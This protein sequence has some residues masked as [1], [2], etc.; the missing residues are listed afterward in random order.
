MMQVALY[1]TFWKLLYR[2]MK[3]SA[4]KRITEKKQAMLNYLLFLHH[5]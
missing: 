1:I 3:K 2:I 4:V 5:S